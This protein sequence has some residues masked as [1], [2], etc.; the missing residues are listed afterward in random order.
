MFHAFFRALRAI[1]LP[2]LLALPAS[3][4]AATVLH[5]EV[6]AVL[7][8]IEYSFGGFYDDTYD[9]ETGAEVG[10][11]GPGTLT[12]ENDTWGLLPEI[13]SGTTRVFSF[14]L[15]LDQT[16]PAHHPFGSGY[17]LSDCAPHCRYQFLD[18]Y[19]P[20]PLVNGGDFSW[21]S[22]PDPD[23]IR[24]N[25][26]PGETLT[27]FDLYS[28]NSGYVPGSHLWYDF[29]DTDYYYTVTDTRVSEIVPA[30]L[31]LGAALLPGAFGVLALLGRRRAA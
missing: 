23:I 27:V 15:H 11:I 21:Y 31:P 14:S 4:A 19:A 16:S 26:N 10:W 12:P 18:W 3:P 29:T 13:A 5:F 9:P 6:E 25:I 22:G 30:P 2:A 28:H 17:L 24:G 8:R 1:G 7:D 20:N